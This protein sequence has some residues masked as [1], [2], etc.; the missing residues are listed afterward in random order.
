MSKVNTMN[1]DY[2]VD[3]GP[4]DWVSIG[5]GISGGKVYLLYRS[6]VGEEFDFVEVPMNDPNLGIPGKAVK[7]QRVGELEDRGECFMID[8]N[9]DLWYL[10]NVEKEENNNYAK[11]E[12]CKI[13]IDGNIKF[14]GFLNQKNVLVLD[15]GDGVLAITEN[16][17]IYSVSAEREEYEPTF[18]QYSDPLYTDNDKVLN[19][20]FLD[21][22]YSERSW[23]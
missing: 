15:G 1:W 9:N 2:V 12:Y 8:E 10:S 20:H 22:M 4:Y 18:W 7:L 6:T 16:G 11:L 23:C 14:T 17:H 21:R 5:F 13:N 19:A 3:A